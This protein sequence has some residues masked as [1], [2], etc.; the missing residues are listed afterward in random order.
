MFFRFIEK[1]Q[2]DIPGKGVK[3]QLE[4]L[5]S[6][7]ALFLLHKHLGD[8]LS[9][10]CINPKQGSLAS[11]QL[12]NLYSQVCPKRFQ[13]NSI[14]WCLYFSPLIWRLM[15]LCV[16][17]SVLMQLRLLMHLTTLITTL[18][19]FLD[20]TMEMCIRSC[21]RRH[22]RILWMIQLF[23]MALKS[24]FNRCLSNNYVMLGSSS[25]CGYDAFGI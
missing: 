13:V 16:V 1:L 20:V 3:K 11:E 25:F 14:F 6:I 2:Q 24:I 9:T 8:F 7:Y 10:G 23:L 5:C 22:G 18:V 19:Q 21:T 17:R 4:V 12:R 15:I